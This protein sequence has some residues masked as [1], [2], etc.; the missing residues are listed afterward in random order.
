MEY[1]VDGRH[2]KEEGIHF[3]FIRA[4][5]K[6]K[7]F[8]YNDVVALVEVKCVNPCFL[9][10]LPSHTAPQIPASMPGE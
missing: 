4:K 8:Y 10:P 1:G 3:N 5:D 2:R 6:E 9:I 7:M